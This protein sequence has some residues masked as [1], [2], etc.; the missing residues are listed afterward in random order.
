[1]RYQR[2]SRAIKKLVDARVRKSDDEI[3][4]AMLCLAIAE[5][6]Y[7][8]MNER[9]GIVSTYPPFKEEFDLVMRHRE[10]K[11]QQEL[12][13]EERGIC[14]QPLHVGSWY[15]RSLVCSFHSHNHIFPRPVRLTVS[16]NIL[17]HDH[18]ERRLK[19]FWS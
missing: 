9:L 19:Y 12:R 3:K 6:E 16:M 2:I 1:M 13:K 7:H 4:Q 10:D 17:T 15:L 5:V 18:T 8:E 11:V 14:L